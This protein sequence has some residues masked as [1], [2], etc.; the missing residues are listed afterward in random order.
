M[1][2]P[3]PVEAS[4]SLAIAHVRTRCDDIHH[5]MCI[6][7]NGSLGLHQPDPAFPDR[8]LGVCTGC[9][10][11]HILDLIPDKDDAVIV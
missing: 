3:F 6:A 10:R 5:F 8:L 9:Q 7:C 4:V 11:W 1:G 2:P